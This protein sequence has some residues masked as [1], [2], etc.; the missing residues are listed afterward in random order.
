MNLKDFP[1][2]AF[3]TQAAHALF[4]WFVVTICYLHWGWNGAGLGWAAFVFYAF[5]KELVWDQAVE[6]QKFVW[7]GLI[8]LGFLLGGCSF[9]LAA[10]KYL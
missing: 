7:N 9:A 4:G 1:S 6:Q 8:D 5:L 10:V 3:I 2:A